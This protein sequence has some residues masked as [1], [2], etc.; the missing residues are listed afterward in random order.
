MN[1]STNALLRRKSVAGRAV[2]GEESV[3]RVNKKLTHEA[4]RNKQA[5]LANCLDAVSCRKL[6]PRENVVV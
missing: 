2:V 3:E 1:A 5:W 6:K 4:A